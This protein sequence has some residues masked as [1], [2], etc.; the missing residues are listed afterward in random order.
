MDTTQLALGTFVNVCNRKLVECQDRA[1]SGRTELEMLKRAA[2]S[3]RIDCSSHHAEVSPAPTQGLSWSLYAPLFR[4]NKA[5]H[6]TRCARP[7]QAQNLRE[8]LG[9]MVAEVEEE[10]LK[11]MIATEEAKRCPTPHHHPRPTL[12]LQGEGPMPRDG[13]VPYATVCLPCSNK[14]VQDQFVSALMVS[15]VYSETSRESF[16]QELAAT[17]QQV[18]HRPTALPAHLCNAFEVV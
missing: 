17:K 4:V 6:D 2:S 16:K 8:E 18:S 1:A 11:S 7:W 3:A 10:K 5:I 12:L 14:R 15:A 9:R 13:C